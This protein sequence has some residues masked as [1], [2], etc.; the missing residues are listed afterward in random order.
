MSDVNNF[1]NP[2]HFYPCNQ[3]IL[4][5]KIFS[6]I[7][8]L[9]FFFLLADIPASPAHDTIRSVV[10]SATPKSFSAVFGEDTSVVWLFCVL[11]SAACITGV[12]VVDGVASVAGAEGV[13]GVGSVAGS[14]GVGVGFGV[15]AV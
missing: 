2:A 8:Y 7:S 9:A 1:F 11:S 14:D 13:D 4:N 6:T 10:Q 15:E 3:L 5:Q 12:T